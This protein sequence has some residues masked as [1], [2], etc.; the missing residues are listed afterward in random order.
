MST[1]PL[2]SDAEAPPPTYTDTTDSAPPPSYDSI[3]GQIKD[4]KTKSSG[5]ADFLKSVCVIIFSTI[6]FTIFIAILLCIPVAM[7]VVG[8]LNLDNCPLER[9]IPIWLVVAGSVSAFMQLGSIIKK[10]KA[11]CDGIEDPDEE[12]QSFSVLNGLN[13]LIG[14]FNIAWFFA[15]NVWVYR[16]YGKQDTTDPLSLNYCDAATYYFAFWSITTAYIILAIVCCC[17][18]CIAAGGRK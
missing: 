1:T 18:C 3:F 16:V 6:G 12:A 15:G 7:I 5:G 13:G 2:K 10:I 9:F 14:C 11:K 8:A 4:A 17:S